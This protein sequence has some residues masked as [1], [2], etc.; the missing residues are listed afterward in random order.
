MF[1]T[2]AA[3]ALQAAAAPSVEPQVVRWAV[4]PTAEEL[5]RYYPMEARMVSLPGASQV[6]CLVS[7]SGALEACALL[8]E[9]PAGWGFGRSALRAAALFRL[10]PDA[11]P[12]LIGK[13]VQLPVFRWSMRVEAQTCDLFRKWRATGEAHPS[14]TPARIADVVSACD[15]Q[16]ATHE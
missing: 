1:S 11:V 12:D 13:R 9:T 5:T 3:I 7:D 6:D 16:V 4:A 8:S 10:S 14:F 2:F 15:E